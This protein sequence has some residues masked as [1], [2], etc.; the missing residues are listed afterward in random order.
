MILQGERRTEKSFKC[1]YK[2][3]TFNS[4]IFFAIM[5]SA[6]QGSVWSRGPSIYY[7]SQTTVWVGLEN[8]QT[9]IQY[10]ICANRVGG[11]EKNQNYDDILHGWSLGQQLQAV[12]Q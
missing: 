12:E 1:M 8:G 7:V 2:K 11:S 9:D 4:R 10:C 6:A 3:S 5:F